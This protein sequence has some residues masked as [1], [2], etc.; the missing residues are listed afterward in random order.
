MNADA[1]PVGG[2][3]KRGGGQGRGGVGEKGRLEAYRE[4]KS[5]CCNV[6]AV[7]IESPGPVAKVVV[8]QAISRR[9]S[10]TV[11]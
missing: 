7:A 8:A 11:T 3:G 2:G 1:A 10:V 6:P 9:G 5:H 4:K